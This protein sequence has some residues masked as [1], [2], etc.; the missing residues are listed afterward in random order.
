MFNSE[1][2][3]LNHLQ[4][5]KHIE[6]VEK[7]GFT[8][9]KKRDV[10]MPTAESVIS[11]VP[12]SVKGLMMQASLNEEEFEKLLAEKMAEP[13]P[14][15]G[16]DCLFCSHSSESLEANMEHMTVAHSFFIPD[17]EFLV[18]LPGLLNVLARKVGT[19]NSCLYCRKL[20][21]SVEAAQK[22]M[23]DKGHAKVW[24]EDDADVEY[25]DFYDFSSIYEDVDWEDE[26]DDMSVV[27]EVTTDSK[28]V[29][30]VGRPIL[31][32]SQVSQDATALYLPTGKTAGHRAYNRY[33]KQ[34]LKPEETRDSVLIQ[35]LK[36]QYKML[37]WHTVSQKMEQARQTKKQ[38]LLVSRKHVDFKAKVGLTHN[39]LQ[40]YFRLQNPM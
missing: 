12:T 18:D 24:Y 22:H 20:F 25:Q 10:V 4:S 9:E 3:Y 15:S 34:T 19:M 26:D 21:H 33:W 13:C 23:T 37:G 28:Q 32:P 7:T 38:A 1:N 40:R 35:R 36:G 27:D 8:E 30:V 2:A 11:T 5:K 14:I 39:G 17:L 29:A 6:M 31:A 16:T